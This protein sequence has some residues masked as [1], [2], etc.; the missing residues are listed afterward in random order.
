MNRTFTSIEEA[1]KAGLTATHRTVFGFPVEYEGEHHPGLVPTGYVYS[2]AD[3]MARYLAMY[4]NR[5]MLDGARVLPEARVT[6]MLTAATNERAIQLQSQQFPARYGAGWFVG[7]FGGAEE[8]RWHQGSLPHFTA[9]MV[10]LPESRDGIVVLLNAGNQFEFA[11]A[12]RGWSRIPEGLVQLVRGDPPPEASAGPFYPLFG[13]LVALALGVQLWSL[14]RVAWTSSS[15]GTDLTR[16]VPL[17]WE[18]GLAVA[19]LL[20]YP[21]LTGGLGWRATLEFLP[22][23]SLT[24]L[25]AAALWLLTG[26]ARLLRQNVLR[27]SEAAAAV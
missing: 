3:D 1:E 21:A 14:Y 9:W 5:G 7:A 27:S 22:D 16:Y 8:A 24:V 20:G 11:G 25:V 23:L 6:E 2:T 12:N 10:L 4:L 15:V 17:L 19:L 13:A 18:F 26:I